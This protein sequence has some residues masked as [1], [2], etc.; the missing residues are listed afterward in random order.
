MWTLS[1]AAGG[2]VPY[3][4]RDE[5]EAVIVLP[6]LATGALLLAGAPV[7]AEQSAETPK[8]LV[9]RKPERS[10]GSKVRQAKDC[11]TSGGV[12]SGGRESRPTAPSRAPVKTPQA[13]P[14]QRP[15][16]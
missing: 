7:V 16:G 13:E 5:E 3:L 11:R 6:L 14:G 9:C 2:P 8:R 4:G 10:L 15:P 1:I 12:E